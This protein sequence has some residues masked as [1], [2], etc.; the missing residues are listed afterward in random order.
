MIS[1]FLAR[2]KARQAR[3]G[4][5]VQ[6]FL[7]MGIITANIGLFRDYFESYGISLRVML[8]IGAFGYLFG[9]IALGWI[10][11]KYGVWQHENAYNSNLNPVMRKV[12]ENQDKMIGILNTT[13]TRCRPI[14]RFT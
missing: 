3:G 1:S 10:D 4:S 7:N 8:I 13:K 6:F 11:E 5:W 14:R 12:Q 2:F 9:T